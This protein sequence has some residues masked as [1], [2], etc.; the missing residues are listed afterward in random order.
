MKKSLGFAIAYLVMGSIAMAE[1]ENSMQPQSSINDGLYFG[2]QAGYLKGKTHHQ[3]VENYFTPVPP[4]GNSDPDGSV[5]GL[6][7]GYQKYYREY[8][9]GLEAD[10]TMSGAK[11]SFENNYGST[12]AGR[13]DINYMY[14]LR[15]R[16]G[17]QFVNWNTLIYLTAGYM[18]AQVD[19]KGGPANNPQAGGYSAHYHGAIVGGGIEKS[20]GK[21]IRLRLEYRYSNLGTETG[22]LSPTFPEVAMPVDLKVHQVLG[23]VY[24]QF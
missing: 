23:A 5:A 6:F 12:S 4:S 14:S 8:L 10:Y 21:H 19:L 16:I 1:M 24:Y 7:I 2:V 22:S 15:A 20:Y 13:S 11:G 3:Y 9:F 17:Y 18:G